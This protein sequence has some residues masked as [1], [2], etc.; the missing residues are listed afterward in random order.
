MVQSKEGTHRQ[1]RVKT[2]P[3]FK[4][5]LELIEGPLLITTCKLRAEDGSRLRF[6]SS[7]LL[8]GIMRLY[9]LVHEKN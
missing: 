6:G 1:K 3:S 2:N 7:D 9:L 5:I 4:A 8:I